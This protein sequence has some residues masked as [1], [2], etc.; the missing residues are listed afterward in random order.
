MTK[1]EY[2]EIVL[3]FEQKYKLFGK[4]NFYIMILEDELKIIVKGNVIHLNK[5]LTKEE[6]IKKVEQ[7]INNL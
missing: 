4:E 5:Q 6:V 2:G 3:Y 1:E 7:I